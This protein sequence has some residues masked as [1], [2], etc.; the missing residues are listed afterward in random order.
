M[1]QQ[2]RLGP[3]PIEPLSDVAW[4]RVE[5]GLW[6]RIDNATVAPAP[7]PT[8][9]RRWIRIAGP[10]LAAAAVLAVILGTRRGNELASDGQPARVVSGA[11]PSSVSFG[12]AHVTLDAESA[13]VMTH[14][15]TTPSALL[16]HGGA[17]FSVAPRGSR[18]PFVVVAGDTIVR[19]VGT[20]FHVARSGER[21]SV[22]VDHG[23]VE[24]QLRGTKVS[25]AAGQRWS[26]DHPTE[27]IPAPR[28][29]QLEPAAPSDEA[30]PAEPVPSRPVAE[31]K[32]TKPGTRI[33]PKSDRK[34]EPGND[35]QTAELERARYEHLAAIEVRS[36]SVALAGYIEL[37]H[38]T[39]RWAEVALFAAG[40]LAAD[41]KDPRATSLLETYL[42]QFPGGKNADDARELIAH[43]KGDSR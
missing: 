17:W 23:L 32:R 29:A 40:R 20:R 6:T 4:V 12:D 14:D 34:P 31:P 15:T 22:A 18:P 38:G 21:A 42:K 9:T 1:S 24:V 7:E 16:E 25:V 43:V 39:S 19:V 8:P 41:R 33:D 3:P 27:V 35:T 11:S 37:A 5:R 10:V 28:T 26:S 30:G 13:L 2:D 36:P